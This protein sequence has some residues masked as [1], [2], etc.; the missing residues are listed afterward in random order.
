LRAV[1]SEGLS[2]RVCNEAVLLRTL[3]L[4]SYRNRTYSSL[5]GPTVADLK[6]PEN[7]KYAK[8]DEWV[9]VEGDVVTIGISDFAQDQLNDIVYA[10]Y[11]VSPN[12]AVS[13]GDAIASVES[14]KAA[15]DIYSPVSGTVL[16]I[17]S[18]VEGS[19]ET[20]NSDPYEGGWLVKIRVDS[21]PDLSGLMDATAYQT[22]NKG[23]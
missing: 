8:S 3:F 22:Y 9:K 11:I 4:L 19:P 2:D 1:T 5:K 13:A 7:L 20:L 16:E 18:A 23:R 12:A 6:F 17:N 15:S 14:V 10:E 21:E